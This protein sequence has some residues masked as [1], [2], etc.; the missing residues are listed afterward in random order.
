MSEEERLSPS[1][2]VSAQSLASLKSCMQDQAP[3]GAAVSAEQ[4]RLRPH[5]GRFEAHVRQLPHVQQGKQGVRGV[6]GYDV[7]RG[8]QAAGHLLQEGAQRHRLPHERAPHAVKRLWR[9]ALTPFSHR[10]GLGKLGASGMSRCVMAGGRPIEQ[11]NAPGAAR[12]SCPE[13]DAWEVKCC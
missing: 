8:R 5:Q 11:Q 7:G 2:L 3:E 9:H 6:S 13:R 4:G 12:V 10:A 1:D